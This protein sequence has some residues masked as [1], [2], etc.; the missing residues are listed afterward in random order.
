MEKLIIK[1]ALRRLKKVLNKNPRLS[2][3]DLEP[4]GVADTFEI[5]TTKERAIVLD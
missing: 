4:Y 1:W 5:A 2:Y 3:A